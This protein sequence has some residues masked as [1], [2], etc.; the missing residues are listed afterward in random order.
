MDWIRSRY[1]CLTSRGP[2]SPAETCAYFALLPLAWLYGGVGLIRSALYRIGLMR[3]V[4]FE[5][6]VVSV[7]NLAVGGTGKTPMVDYI[8]KHYLARGKQVAV[9]SRGYGGSGAGEI[10]IV[11][12]GKNILLSA[13]VAGDEPRL[14]AQ[15]NPGLIVVV[16]PRRGRGVR[17][18]IDRFG[19]ELIVLDD[20]FQHLAVQRD[21]DIVLLDAQRP[22]GNGK[23]LPAG[24]LREFPRALNRGHLFVLTK[25]VFR[26]LP[27]LPLPGP[28]L[29]S[30]HLLAD[31]AVSL[32]GQTRDLASLVSQRVAAFAGIADPESFFTNLRGKGFNL[33]AAIPFPD[34]VSYQHAEITR[35]VEAGRDA[36]CLMT[37]EKDAVKLVQA[38]FSIP[39]YRVPLKLVIDD[40]TVLTNDLD[41][42]LAKE[43]PMTIKQELLDIL[44]CPKCK[45]KIRLRENPLALLCDSCRLAYPI[46]ENIP[47]MLIDE[48]ERVGEE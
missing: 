34:H 9:V 10:G 16:A 11:S 32:D 5:V 26:D 37:T 22:F 33:V 25:A 13:D 2:E 4:R 28:T 24:L 20:G 45:G 12:D 41:R 40:R 36:D 14:L 1:R 17:A 43:N 29:V 6:P 39:C 44:A 35:I 18:A 21:L 47:V 30:R 3:S 42:L 15:R 46:R 31:T 19:A 27:V 48:A 7:G 23:V 8:A 38:H